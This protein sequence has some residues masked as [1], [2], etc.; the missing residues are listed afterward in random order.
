MEND[1]DKHDNYDNSFMPNFDR[2]DIDTTKPVISISNILEQLTK[3]FDS[4]AVAQKVYDKHFNNPES[5]YYQMTIEQIV[6]AWSN[7]GAESCRYGS[8][9]DDYIGITLTKT[10][11]DMEL[12]KLD[13][14]YDYDERLHGLCDSFDNFYKVLTRS[15]DMQFIDR[16]KTVYYDMGE[17]YV[18]GR[19]DALFRNNKT[20]K[21]VVID[22]KSSGIIDKTNRF[23]KLLGPAMKFDACNW[24]TYTMQLYFYKKTLVDSGY[25]PAGTTYDDV[26]VLIVHMPGHV[27]EDTNENYEICKAA[28]PFDSELMTRIYWFGFRKKQLLEKQ[29]EA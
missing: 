14:N 22:W 9:L 21:W 26:E 2:A 3:P 19:F 29:K 23:D 27:I 7:K 12:Y 16:E 25:L 1:Y 4:A 20:G 15:G 8:L 6:E 17:F 11:D 5:Q 13:H 18:K 28:F 24:N 10:P